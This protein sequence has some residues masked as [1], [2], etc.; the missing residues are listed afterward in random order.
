MQAT[1]K[2]G[3]YTPSACA[4]EV[5]DDENQLNVSPPRRRKTRTAVAGDGVSVHT[6][7]MCTS[8]PSTAH[9]PADATVAALSCLL[10]T[11]LPG[12][13]KRRL[14]FTLAEREENSL[15]TPGR[16]TVTSRLTA[17]STVPNASAT[18]SSQV[19]RNYA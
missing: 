9:R 4:P 8:Q 17:I 16:S 11:T 1:N 6:R 5:D 14:L 3:R 12:S 2:V 13:A 15:T 19:T 7:C 18:A 10:P